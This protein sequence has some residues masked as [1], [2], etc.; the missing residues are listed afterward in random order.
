MKESVGGEERKT[1]KE[2]V[3]ERER[4]RRESKEIRVQR[5]KEQK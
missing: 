4:E 5:R 3:T 1:R 2:E